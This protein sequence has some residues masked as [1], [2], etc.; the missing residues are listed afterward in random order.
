MEPYVKEKY[1]PMCHMHATKNVKKGI[2]N[3]IQLHI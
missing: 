2:Y 1:L 3:I